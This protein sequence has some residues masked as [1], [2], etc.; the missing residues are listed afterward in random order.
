MEN[1]GCHIPIQQHHGHHHQQSQQQHFNQKA[2]TLVLDGDIFQR[3]SQIG[4]SQ[5]FTTDTDIARFLI[6]HYEST[7]DRVQPSVYCVNCHNP[8]SLA[9]TKCDSAMLQSSSLQVSPDGSSSTFVTPP[10][11]DPL[12]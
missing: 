5:G 3:W 2:Q 9:C 12:L 4:T 6:Q 1:P 8:M 10:S 11:V 7:W